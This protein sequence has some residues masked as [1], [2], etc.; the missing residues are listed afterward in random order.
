MEKADTKTQ[1]ELSSRTAA[2]FSWLEFLGML[3]YLV[4][5]FTLGRNHWLLIFAVLM[6]ASGYFYKT[7]VAWKSGNKKAVRIRIVILVVGLAL[8]LIV[9]YIAGQQH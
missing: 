2:V 8:A 5:S 3:V 6:L 1:T 7:Y 4:V 9:G